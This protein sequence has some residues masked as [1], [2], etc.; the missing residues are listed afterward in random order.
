MRV[1]PQTRLTGLTEEN[2]AALVETARLGNVAAFEE[3]YRRHA[4][5][6]WRVAQAVTA[7][8][9]DAAD[10]VS[11]AFVRVFAALPAGRLEDASQ[12]RAYLLASTRNA[13]IDTMRK[14]GRARPTDS[15]ADIASTTGPTDAVLASEDCRIVAEA[16]RDLPERWRS[17]LWLTEVEGMPT[18]EVGARLGLSPNGVAQLAV[19]A[20]AGLRERFIQAHLRAD[21][22]RKCRFTVDRLGAYV[23]GK[24]A[25]RDL[26]KVDQHLAGCETCRERK[27]QIEDVGGR[28]RAIV[29]P[30]P[31]LLGPQ[32]LRHFKGANIAS[33]LPASAS[34]PLS[35]TSSLATKAHKPLLTASAG[36]FALGVISAT[37]VAGPNAPLR[38]P[39]TP[40]AAIARGDDAPA[41]PPE[42]PAAPRT[43]NFRNAAFE[44]P[45]DFDA[46]DF[47]A[48]T[49]QAA[50]P[51]P[52]VEDERGSGDGEVAIADPTPP[53][54]PPPT[55]TD[56]A[57]LAQAAIT[58][59]L[60]PLGAGISLGAGDDAC[61]GGAIYGQ[62]ALGCAPDE[63]TTVEDGADDAEVSVALEGTELG[64]LDE[65]NVTIGL[66]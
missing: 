58:V 39:R 50:A 33:A 25:P 59:A 29:L 48:F 34:S 24:L 20:R 31:M 47:A 7:N 13:A 45:P 30:L 61:S 14:S 35:W 26:A 60:G 23:A 40:P 27:D 15:F 22:D 66:P 56:P 49:T 51:P 38:G 18:R 4:D 5:S 64:P 46:D 16:F 65:T 8:A 32:V 10:A 17:V 42:V 52:P 9:H 3:L 43:V 41:P 19:R 54:P 37:V 57:P 63:P 6:A 55:E 44:I 62:G 28:L 11:D 2:D 53:P 21:V 12:F 1:R 36:L